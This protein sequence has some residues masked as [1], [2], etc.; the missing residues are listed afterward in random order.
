MRETSA[1]GATLQRNVF[2]SHWGLFILQA[3]LHEECRLASVTDAFLGTSKAKKFFQQRLFS[4]I[5]RQLS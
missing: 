4:R 5:L 3:I 1:E 2:V